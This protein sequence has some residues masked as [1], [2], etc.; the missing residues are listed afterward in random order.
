MGSYLSQ[1]GGT[2]AAGDLTNAI[3]NDRLSLLCPAS[4]GSV[5]TSTVTWVVNMA[6]A[7][8]NSILGTGFSV[9]VATASVTNVIKRCAT[10]IAVHFAYK[11]TTEFR[12]QD[13]KTPVHIDYEDARKVLTEIKNGA[14]TMGSTAATG[15]SGL[16]GGTV[17]ASTSRFIVEAS[18]AT[19]NGPT[20][21]W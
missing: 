7:E 4:N 5:S 20:G 11:R 16:I 14:R 17:Y 9:P 13:G 2:S 3:G 6:E 10:D 15:K 12:G 1:T 21:G 18:E 8:V 19:T